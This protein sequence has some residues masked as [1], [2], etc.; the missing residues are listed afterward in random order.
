MAA[1]RL[2]PANLTVVKRTLRRELPSIKSTHLTEAIAA[3]L[4]FRTHAALLTAVERAGPGSEP[5]ANFDAARATERLSE[6]SYT[7]SVAALTTAVAK[8]SELPDP[9]WRQSHGNDSVTQNAWF[10]ECKGLRLPYV[11][12]KV[13]R[14][15][16][17]LEWDCITVDANCDESVR[18]DKSRELVSE[19]FSLFQQH[20]VAET[21][22]PMFEGS[23]FVGSIERLL[24]ETACALADEFFGRLYRATRAKSINVAA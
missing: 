4:G 11:V 10:H 18:G 19:M 22:Q 16:A 3:A 15:Y 2:T 17:T 9:C 23:A 21:G 20:C 12:V 8:R 5:I 14:K 6:L 1:L 13:A 24:P 7:A